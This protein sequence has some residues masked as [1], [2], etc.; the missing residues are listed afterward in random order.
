MNNAMKNV[1]MKGP[2]QDLSIQRFSFFI[3]LL[4]S[5]NID[6]N[7]LIS[8]LNLIASTG[9]IYKNVIKLQGR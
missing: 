4:P 8:S 1:N 9:V 6:T 2:K 5:A 7:H 3:G